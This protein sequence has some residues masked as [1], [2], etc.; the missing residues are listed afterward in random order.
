MSLV[1]H[2]RR[3]DRKGFDLRNYL[4][5]LS[6]EGHP[7]RSRLSL[8]SSACGCGSGLVW[9]GR[10]RSSW[11]WDQ[12]GGGD[13]FTVTQ[14]HTTLRR[15]RLRSTCWFLARG[16]W[17]F[18]PKDDHLVVLL[19]L[20][21]SAWEFAVN[22]MVLAGQ[23]SIVGKDTIVLSWWRGEEHCRTRWIRWPQEGPEV[24]R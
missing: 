19:V 20:R 3:A 8:E 6:H 2:I 7:G 18:A 17:V 9:S 14:C 1:V 12:L 23:S 5:R 10:W 24:S 22:D 11:S 16:K 13:D 21:R 15:E 4:R